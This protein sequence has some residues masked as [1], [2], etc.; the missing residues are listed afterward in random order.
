MRSLLALGLLALSAAVGAATPAVSETIV[1]KA[2]DTLSQIAARY[3]GDARQWRKLYDAR[4]SG[5]SNP[6]V[7]IAGDV[8]ELVTEA[9]G[10]RYLRAIGSTAAPTAAAALAPATAAA[11]VVRVPAAVPA[12]VVAPAAPAPAPALAPAVTVSPP[13]AQQA[14]GTPA[15]VPGE[16]VIGVVPY[17]S[18]AT[19]AAQYEPLKR[20]LERGGSTRVRIVVPG[21]FKAFF[22]AAVAGEFDVAISPPHMARVAQLDRGLMPLGVFEPRIGAL[23][24]TPTEG[25]IS[26]PRDVAGKAVGFA[27]PQSLVAMYGQQWLRGQ[28]LEAGRDYESK[29]ARTDLGVGRMMLTGE[30]VAAIMSTG[31]FRVL[32]PEEATRMRIV[33]TFARIPNF[34]WLAH[35][36][37]ERARA[38]R[39]RTQMRDFFADAEDGAAFTKATGLTGF[40]EATDATLRELD[41]FNSATR[42]AMGLAAR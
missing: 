40:V 42:R 8:L 9:N 21:N 18:A 6:N 3:T 11:S 5:L 34:I 17:I 37:L 12:P 16:L 24:V 4:K 36:R 2:G 23:L 29:G 27:N 38:D 15:S 33:E 41:P 32:P 7:I 35:P 13:A 10:S 22:D 25:G 30:A 28:N 1:I 39:L 26:S 14:G 20:Y 31:E 19:L